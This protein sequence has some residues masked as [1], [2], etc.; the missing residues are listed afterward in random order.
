MAVSFALVHHAN[1]FLITDGYD[2][3]EGISEI[4]GSETKRT[5]MLGL[6]AVHA[7]EGVP[8]N[9][10][11]SGTF[12]EAMS[13]H[14]P[15]AISVLREAI[16][17]GLVAPIGSCYGQNIMRFFSANYNLRQL[18]EELRLFELLLDVDPSQVKIFWP[19]ERVWDTKTMAPV[20]RDRTLLNEGYRYVIV[21]DRTLL[22][23]R[24]PDPRSAYDKENRWLP[25]LY[26][27][28]EIENVL[29]SLRCQ[30]AFA[31]VIRFRLGSIR[32]G[33]GYR[34]NSRRF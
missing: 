14:H 32:T 11:I 19:P 3:R 2:T 34:P 20:L 31:S 9:L 13:W 4:V 16:H 17:Q 18:T 24:D 22:S 30:S 8:L 10:H 25:E 27:T 21:D 12:L 15:S 1:Q 6:L 33:S 23:T 28:H 7:S 5:G 29:A 26:Q